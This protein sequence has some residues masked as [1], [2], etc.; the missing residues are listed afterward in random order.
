MNWQERIEQERQRRLAPV[1]AEQRRQLEVQKNTESFRHTALAILDRLRVADM[2][3]DIRRNVWHGGLVEPFGPKEE[4]LQREGYSKEDKATIKGLALVYRYKDPEISDEEVYAQ[5]FGFY[6]VVAG[7]GVDPPT[8]EVVG[9]KLGRHQALVGYK[10]KLVWSDRIAAI[11]ILVAEIEPE[12]YRGGDVVFQLRVE[13]N[14]VFI[15]QMKGSHVRINEDNVNNDALL[16][17]FITGTVTG[18]LVSFIDHR[19]TPHLIDEDIKKRTEEL[20]RE[21]RELMLID[22]K[23]FR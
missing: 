17:E 19:R 21:I 15:N 8:Y 4:Y 1:H 5:K 20:Q 14:A 23:V 2:L 12:Y 6:N 3:D 10:R 16:R 9:T 18:T 22:R 11:K 13:D 7:R